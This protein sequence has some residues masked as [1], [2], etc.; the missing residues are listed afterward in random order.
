V[1]RK[2]GKKGI[3]RKGREGLFLGYRQMRMGKEV[4]FFFHNPLEKVYFNL[5]KKSLK[6]LEVCDRGDKIMNIADHKYYWLDGYT[7]IGDK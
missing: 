1:S 4:G 7:A 2:G 6:S 3:G 5:P